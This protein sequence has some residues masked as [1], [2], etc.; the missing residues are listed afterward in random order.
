[1]RWIHIV[2][3]A[4][5]TVF[6][7]WLVL[8][9][10]DVLWS[11]LVEGSAYAWRIWGAAAGVPIVGVTAAWTLWSGRRPWAS[12]VMTAAW[13]GLQISGLPWKLVL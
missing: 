1:V 6:A 2:F 5:S 11:T 8:S 4:A 9:N 13:I 3:L 7:S 10:A 12:W